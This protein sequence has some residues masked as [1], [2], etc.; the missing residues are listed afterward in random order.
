VNERRG[1]RYKGLLAIAV[2]AA[3]VVVGFLGSYVNGYL[4]ET[5]E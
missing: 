2:I 4:N 1:N 3:Y 5:L